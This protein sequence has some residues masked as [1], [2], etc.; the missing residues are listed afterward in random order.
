MTAAAFL[1]EQAYVVLPAYLFALLPWSI[2][3]VHD[4]ISETWKTLEETR[5]TG[6]RHLIFML[7]PLPYILLYID[8]QRRAG[9]FKEMCTA[10]TAVLYSLYHIGKTIWGLV[11]LRYFEEWAA[12]THSS[13]HSLGFGIPE[14]E[15][16][17]F[18]VSNVII[19]N[20]NGTDSGD[21]ARPC[22]IRLAGG[23]RFACRI[24]KNFYSWQT[25]REGEDEVKKNNKR[26]GN[27]K[28]GGWN[29]RRAGR[30]R[31]HGLVDEDG[32]LL[33][34]RN[35]ISLHDI[36]LAENEKDKED[37][38]HLRLRSAELNQRILARYEKGSLRPVMYPTDPSVMLVRW[39]VSLLSEVGKS[40]VDKW[41]RSPVFK[42]SMNLLKDRRNIYASDVWGTAVLQ[43]CRLDSIET[44]HGI[45]SYMPLRE[46][47]R[48][49]DGLHR[50]VFNLD[51]FLESSLEIGKGL[52]F[53]S[54]NPVVYPRGIQAL[55]ALQSG[56]SS[57]QIELLLASKSVNIPEGPCFDEYRRQIEQTKDSLELL[58]SS[59][60]EKLS[61]LQL[62]W[63]IVIAS[64]GDW[65]GYSRMK[66][67]PTGVK[68]A[69][70]TTSRL[71][72][73]VLSEQLGFSIPV[74]SDPE[75]EG[76]V[77]AYD[78]MINYCSVP[79]F[80]AVP[81]HRGAELPN[82]LDPGL[83]QASA[84][85]DG[86]LT[87]MQLTYGP[88]LWGGSLY[89][90][91]LLIDNWVALSNGEFTERVL[92]RLREGEEVWFQRPTWP[93]QK[94]PDPVGLDR[95][96]TT[97]AT[98][99]RR[100]RNT[101][102]QN[103]ESADSS[104]STVRRVR[105]SPDIR[106]L[107]FPEDVYPRRIETAQ[108]SPQDL[109]ETDA[110]ET[111]ENWDGSQLLESVTDY[112]EEAEARGEHRPGF[113]H[114][115]VREFV[116]SGSQRALGSS[117]SS[118]HRTTDRYG[119]QLDWKND[120][121]KA[122]I[123]AWKRWI[124][125]EYVH[126]YRRLYSSDQSFAL[127]P[128]EKD[129]IARPDAYY[130]SQ[131]WMAASRRRRVAHSLIET[132]RNQRMMLAFHFD[133]EADKPR[134]FRRGD[135]M[136]EHSKIS[137]RGC[138]MEELRKIASEWV[139]Q[140]RSLRKT[141][142]L[143]YNTNITIPMSKE[144]EDR[145]LELEACKD[146][147]HA[148]IRLRLLIEVQYGLYARVKPQEEEKELAGEDSKDVPGG[149][150]SDHFAQEENMS[151]TQAED[152][153]PVQEQEKSFTSEEEL[154]FVKEEDRVLAQDGYGNLVQEEDSNDNL[155]EDRNVVQE[156]ERDI[157][158]DP[159]AMMMCLLS[160]PS[161]TAQSGELC[162]EA[163]STGGR[164]AMYDAADSRKPSTIDQ[165]Y[166]E[167]GPVFGPQDLRVRVCFPR[168]SSKE[169]KGFGNS[170]ET[171]AGSCTASQNCECSRQMSLTFE[172][173]S[174]GQCEEF[175]WQLWKDAF[176]ARR[177]GYLAWQ[178][179]SSNAYLQ[180]RATKATAEDKKAME[181]IYSCKS[182]WQDLLNDE[183]I[184]SRLDSP[185]DVNELPWRGWLSD[186]FTEPKVRTA[187][188]SGGPQ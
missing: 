129:R 119:S 30:A 82:L 79:Y 138:A 174:K 185:W 26:Q 182:T 61:S 11:Q 94:K 31:G 166:V 58:R 91:S 81:L 188:S 25:K 162:E 118:G 147:N 170:V 157:T 187:P 179:R 163:E 77:E 49:K 37:F 93:S 9:D 178:A 8:F 107:T 19:D 145:L 177:E 130:R 126:S 3:L 14:L 155:E 68:E 153:E 24:R 143:P 156:T 99:S 97:H 7:V 64:I 148:S 105:S 96:P 136:R 146:L 160:F 175:H 176:F 144:L 165:W 18:V 45:V 2:L 35:D 59:S 114:E 95:S 39:A 133:I 53:S 186:G 87:D 55:R 150:E 57:E 73:K 29:G 12:N 4:Y 21:T 65:H 80:A 149:G 137:F 10:T 54:P 183:R 121:P 173:D 48:F 116:D 85:A 15:V 44:P 184:Q 27:Q 62:K 112:T 56:I 180:S 60:V 42:S 16:Q 47:R 152:W 76:Q 20:E 158:T 125:S 131:M 41:A 71:G 43:T 69:I 154:P 78:A 123:F 13:L 70:G 28:R 103:I 50:V 46:W 86:V 109:P 113:Y 108:K 100:I 171:D 98:I 92:G 128:A 117:F 172:T 89:Q 34:V 52:P 75:S 181:G 84:Q 32:V 6:R 140:G 127:T 134:P 122:D 5:E 115:P 110:T 36:D 169:S 90:V 101:R 72:V 141:Q 66:S 168:K 159:A 67:V 124:V 38:L 102:L 111:S 106:R 1:A 33:V 135:G 51:T 151:V 74:I 167:F 40:F 83:S 139:V 161:L 23:S 17:R 142:P 22:G 104:R 132:P 88:D 164:P 63:L 120:H